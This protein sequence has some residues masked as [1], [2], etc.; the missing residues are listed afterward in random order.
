MGDLF[1]VTAPSGLKLRS[2]PSTDAPVIIFAMLPGTIVEAL[3][4]QAA[5]EPHFVQVH[6]E[7]DQQ[8]KFVMTDGAEPITPAIA[9]YFSEEGYVSADWLEPAGQVPV[10]E[11][12]PEPQPGPTTP[13]T[14]AGVA[15]TGGVMLLLVAVV[16]AALYAAK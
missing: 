4:A 7:L 13:P 8:N 14:V 2:A 12:Q 3:A 16:A 11:P 15:S 5:E 6:V 1:R 9:N 10:P